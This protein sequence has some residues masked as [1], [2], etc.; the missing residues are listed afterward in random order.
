VSDMIERVARALFAE[1]GWKGISHPAF[2]EDQELWFGYARAALEAMRE[3]TV[4]MVAAAFPCEREMQFSHEDKR[5][6]AAVCLQ[7]G[8]GKDIGLLEGE[9]VKQAAFLARDY[10]IMIDQAL[11]V[12]P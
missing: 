12:Q 9:A 3:P 1:I 6:G 7:L 2:E 11:K 4:E 5:L 8:G 10:R